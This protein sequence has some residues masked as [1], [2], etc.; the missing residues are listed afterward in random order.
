VKS[1]LLFDEA[2][3]GH[4]AIWMEECVR[5][6]REI[7]PDVKLSY[8]FPRPFDTDAH[9]ITWGEPNYHQ[10]LRKIQA[11]TG[12]PVLTAAKWRCLA[13]LARVAKADRVLMMFGDEFLHPGFTP[14]VG[15][16]WV[17][18]YFH[19]RFLRGDPMKPPL[20]TLGADS[21]PY[22]YVL[23]ASIRESLQNLLQKPVLKIPDFCP[24]TRADAT[25]RCDGLRVAADSR[26]IVGAIGPLTA[27]KNIGALIRVA[28]Q[29]P[30]WHFLVAGMLF[31]KSLSP[32]EKV[33]VKEA[34]GMANFTCYFEY[35]PHE[36]LNALTAMCHVQ[37]AAYNR[38]LHSSNKLVRACEYQRPVV[39]ADVGCMGDMVRQYRLGETCDPRNVASVDAAIARCLQA[40]RPLGDWA[41]YEAANSLLA[42]RQA[43]SPLVADN[44]AQSVSSAVLGV[45]VR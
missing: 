17:P 26:P 30:E 11:A 21:C 25:P 18:I 44:V 10:V 39:V 24:M 37:F 6:I 1:I 28:K 36:E 38:F 4:H 20:A 16:E 9:H 35:L 32:S 15:F 27:H 34:Q 7:A 40:N 3:L 41:G 8:A 23:D 12:W 19:P 14:R 45:D 43:L 5:A 31:P 13:T 29:R 42:L 2:F 33:L 22:V